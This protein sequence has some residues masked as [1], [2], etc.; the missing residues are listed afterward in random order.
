MEKNNLIA[1][2][3]PVGWIFC[4]GNGDLSVN[5]S[6]MHVSLIQERDL[7]DFWSTESMGVNLKQFAP[8]TDLKNE[9]DE[10]SI[11]EGP[12]GQ[13][14]VSFPWVR[15][16]SLLPDNKT[17]AEALL[18]NQ[19]RRLLKSPELAR[20]YNEQIEEL[21]K[22]GFARK[23]SQDEI[24][25]YEGPVFYLPHHGVLRKENTSTPLR[26][27]FNSSVVYNGHCLNEY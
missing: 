19:E 24:N 13:W 2:R 11:L 5:H 4:G 3:T 18:Y 23:L 12:G 14:M 10:I 1:R 7:S 21:T 16:A 9:S 26:I 8:G 6:V 20:A 25:Q 15:D 17:Q 27:V 22:L